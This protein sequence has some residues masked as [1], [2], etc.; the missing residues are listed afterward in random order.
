M[1]I[2]LF[3][4][5]TVCSWTA[6]A[7]ID[8]FNRNGSAV[9]GAAMDMSKAFD[10]VEWS[11]LFSTLIKKGVSHIIL[12]LMLYIYESQCC[13]LNWAGAYS[14]SFKVSNGVSFLIHGVL[15]CET[16]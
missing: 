12:R 4:S 16:L 11:E 14:D 10:M 15:Q 1:Y 3:Q 6:T 9:F 8:H 2:Y 5:T 13:V 7:V